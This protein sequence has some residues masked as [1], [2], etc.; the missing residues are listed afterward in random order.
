MS[1][2]RTNPAESTDRLLTGTERRRSKREPHD[3]DA[4]V[5]PADGNT[6]L[7][8][9][10]SIRDLSLGGVGMI[11]K[12]PYRLGTVWRITLGNGPLFL[13]AKVRIVSCRVRAD[14]RFDVGCEFC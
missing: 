3:V 1:G 8:E 4:I 10:V 6:D 5:Q 7:E 9:K 2:V 12:H 13:N 14:K 11:A